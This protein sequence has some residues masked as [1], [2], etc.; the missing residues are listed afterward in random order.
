MIEFCDMCHAIEDPDNPMLIIGD[1][2]VC[3]ACVKSAVRLLAEVKD[4][5]R[6]H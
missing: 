1:D 5:S 2:I 3:E 4:G 6:E